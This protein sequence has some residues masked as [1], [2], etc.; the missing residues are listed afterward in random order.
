MNFY[1]FL[2][3]L[4]LEVTRGS[5]TQQ[6]RPHTH[7]NT[8]FRYWYLVYYLEGDSVTDSTSTPASSRE[9]RVLVTRASHSTVRWKRGSGRWWY[10]SHY[11]VPSPQTLLI[12]LCTYVTSKRRR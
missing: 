3:S 11:L 10:T 5:I 8:H 6:T 4:T 2:F 12:P 1:Y 9:V 7:T